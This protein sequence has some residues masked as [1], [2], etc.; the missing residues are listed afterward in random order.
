MAKVLSTFKLSAS[1]ALGSLK[2]NI[3]GPSSIG[4]TSKA[5]I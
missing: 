3:R 5:I 2:D 1:I 4:G